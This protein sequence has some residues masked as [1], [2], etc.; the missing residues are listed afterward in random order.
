MEAAYPAFYGNANYPV[1]AGG[2]S[3]P[4]K[5]SP[6]ATTS[7]PLVRLRVCDLRIL[8]A[9]VPSPTFAPAPVAAGGSAVASTTSTR[10]F[11]VE[12]LYVVARLGGEVGRTSCLHFT[13]PGADP[14]TV[15]DT[16]HGDA[17]G[18]RDEDEDD[19]L[20]AGG[21][22][23]EARLACLVWDERFEFHPTPTNDNPRGR[24]SGSADGVLEGANPT[25]GSSL[26]ETSVNLTVELELWR[27]TPSSENCIGRYAYNVP[28]EALSYLTRAQQRQRQQRPLS[29]LVMDPG[30]VMDTVVPLR[31]AAA[32]GSG[33]GGAGGMYGYPRSSNASGSAPPLKLGLRLRVQASG[34][35]LPAAH[36]GAG[37]LGA[38]HN[39]AAAAPRTPLVGSFSEAASLGYLGG[40]T[41]G[42]PGML[43]SGAASAS[44]GLLSTSSVGLLYAGG[45]GGLG[46]DGYGAPFHAG[47]G[48]STPDLTGS[49]GVL[50]PF[51]S[52]LLSPMALRS[53]LMGSP[54]PHPSGIPQAMGGTSP[55][56]SL[57][58]G[59]AQ[60]RVMGQPPALMMPGTTAALMEGGGLLQGLS[61]VSPHHQ[62]LS[63]P[64]SGVHGGS[65]G[66]LDS[67]ESP[68]TLGGVNQ[69]AY[70]VAGQHVANA[71]TASH[72]VSGEG[73][74]NSYYPPS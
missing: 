34:V 21:P 25:A 14:S 26:D 17:D 61:Q 49:G 16:Y 64:G 35:S 63:Y 31:L 54:Q 59:A 72:G 10:T 6:V 36:L 57:Y 24:T 27:S 29:S 71:S 58:P 28:M 12:G 22:R 60:H 7:P 41:G 52:R 19:L 42:Y 68:G 62:G 9:H 51:L 39:S 65:G 37:M 47:S 74:F 67:E 5:P 43:P 13:E 46:I 18:E 33:S 73:P 50:E 15:M 66:I 40:S 3:V 38:V 4:L 44:Y 55:H 56:G 48:S 53:T 32:A 69:L 11:C 8:S 70:G 30:T 45:G 1:L 20:V 2:G 23:M